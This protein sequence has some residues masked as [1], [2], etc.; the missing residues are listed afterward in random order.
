MPQDSAQRRDEILREYFLALQII[1]NFD[2]R[3]LQIKSWSVTA[4]G[5]AIAAAYIEDQP[6]LFLLGA[7]SAAIF[8]FI[9]GMWKSFQRI[10]IERSEHLETLLSAGGDYAGP[11]WSAHF[12]Q[13]F[14][15]WRKLQR[16]PRVFLYTNT[17]LPHIFIIIGG[18]LLYSD[19]V[20]ITSIGA[21][22]ASWSAM[23]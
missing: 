16:F 17:Y 14:T 8:W 11:A 20:G 19:A 1:D 6:Q 23:R 4:S 9:E 22:I 5:V 12:R 3:T 7:V 10:V 2:N 15:F 21:H 13:N 18:G